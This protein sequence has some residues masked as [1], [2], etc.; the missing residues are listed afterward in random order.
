MKNSLKNQVVELLKN[1]SCPN[2]VR[3]SIANVLNLLND[4]EQESAVAIAGLEK[5]QSL[6]GVTYFKS[7]S[8]ECKYHFNGNKESN[9]LDFFNQIKG[10]G[11]ARI[12]G[13]WAFVKNPN[14]IKALRAAG[15][16]QVTDKTSDHYGEYYINGYMANIRWNSGLST[17]QIVIALHR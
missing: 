10:L 3:A 16:R 13:H 17:H 12:Q 11:E 2:V 8:F 7:T 14:D 4:L 9:L 5:L 6:E 15:F 1:E